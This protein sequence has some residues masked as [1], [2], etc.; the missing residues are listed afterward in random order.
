[1]ARSTGSEWTSSSA[2]APCR[3]ASFFVAAGFGVA[4]P[5]RSLPQRFHVREEVL[6]G[7]LAQHLAQQHAQRAH[8]AAQRS[9]FQLAGLRLELRQPLRPAF[10]IPQKRHRVLIMHD[11][12]RT[13]FLAVPSRKIRR[14]KSPRQTGTKRPTLAGHDIR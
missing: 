6:A 3:A 10:G 14:R 1:M 5:N 12:Q 4:P 8:V 2:V 11:P 13:P 9:F 7:L